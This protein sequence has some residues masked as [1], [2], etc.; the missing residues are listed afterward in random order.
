MDAYRS[1]LSAFSLGFL[2]CTGAPVFADGSDAQDDPPTKDATADREDESTPS[3]YA[4][5]SEVEDSPYGTPVDLGAVGGESEMQLPWLSA[6]PEQEDMGC[7]L[8]T[9][10]SPRDISGSRMPSSA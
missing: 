7:L 6:S 3:P 4:P 1:A 10:P 8:Y 5:A 9:S 2:L